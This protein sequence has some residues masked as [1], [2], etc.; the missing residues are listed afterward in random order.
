MIKGAFNTT[1]G[2][3]LPTGFNISKTSQLP[4]L[5]DSLGTELIGYSALITAYADN[6]FDRHRWM[7]LKGGLK[8]LVLLYSSVKHFKDNCVILF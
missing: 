6:I 8:G 5:D 1:T 7:G 3:L 2:C 4:R